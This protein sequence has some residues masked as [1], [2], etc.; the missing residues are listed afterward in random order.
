MQ[1]FYK[2]FC[3]YYLI[4]Y[5]IRGFETT[6]RHIHSKHSIVCMLAAES[7]FGARYTWNNV[8]FAHLK[9]FG[10]IPSIPVDLFTFYL[11]IYLLTLHGVIY[12]SSNMFSFNL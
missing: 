7:L 6:L 4:Q 9:N 11:F 8:I 5:L 12:S 1:I 2:S 3:I 10:P